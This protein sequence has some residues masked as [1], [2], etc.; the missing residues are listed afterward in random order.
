M[1]SRLIEV[2]TGVGRAGA[3]GATSVEVGFFAVAVLVAC[4]A[5]T[6]RDLSVWD[7]KAH[8]W[9]MPKG[10]MQ[11]FVGNSSRDLPLHAVLPRKLALQAE[12]A[13]RA[14]LWSDALI[15]LRTVGA[16]LTR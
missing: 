13:A 9:K 7:D 5:L 16:L 10:A 4:F 1:T 11:V 3:F 14:T 15:L 8:G 2:W 6:R 12:Y